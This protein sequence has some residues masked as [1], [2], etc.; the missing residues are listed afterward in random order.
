MAHP[1]IPHDQNTS[2][3]NRIMGYCAIDFG[4]SNSALAIPAEG[5]VSLLAIEDGR[6]TMPTA[7]FY[8]AEDGRKTFGRAAIA[9]YVDGTDG[10][11]LRSIK[12]IL[13]SSLINEVTD[14]GNGTA[15]RY[16]DVIAAFI[17]NLKSRA[18]Q[19]GGRRLDRVV[20]GRPVYFCDGDAIADR[21][22]EEALRA[23]AHAVGFAEVAF[24]LEPLAAAFDYESRLD[25]DQLVLV[26]DIGGGTSDFSLVQ[27]GPARSLIL[28]RTAD[29]LANHG[30][31]VAGTDFDR[32]V[33]L[34]SIMRCLG[35]KAEG[36]DGRPVPH[37][38]YYDL[39]TWHLINLVYTPRRVAELAQMRYFYADTRQ[40]DRLLKVLRERLGHHLAA[41]AEQAKIAVAAS[42]STPA[43][44]DLGVLESGLNARYDHAQ[45][46]RALRAPVDAIVEASLETVRRAG[47]RTGA[48]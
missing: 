45:L 46:D 32:H 38:I 8:S 39:S 11:L 40:H 5:P 36:P 41:L 29:I 18:E 9:S 4:T 48:R 26:A 21:A 13:G 33:E 22:A 28:D 12:S 14:V 37:R 25:A 42:G 19:I 10:R 15:V 47:V 23:A 16:I 6:P 31:H 17:R 2:I 24:Q 7:V 34:D 3:G 35:F 43:E 44:I 20:V 27:L 30:V 1:L